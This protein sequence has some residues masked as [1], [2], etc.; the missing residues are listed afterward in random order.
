MVRFKGCQDEP[1]ADMSWE[2]RVTIMTSLSTTVAHDKKRGES[3]KL[4]PEEFPNVRRQVVVTHGEVTPES[5]RRIA[6][7]APQ[8]ENCFCLTT[9]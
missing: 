7:C 6:S 4:Q 9:K 3:R 5:R 2:G 1:V 8:R